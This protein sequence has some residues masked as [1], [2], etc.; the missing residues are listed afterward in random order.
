MNEIH[1]SRGVSAATP[2]D[3]VLPFEI[4]PLGVRGRLLRLGAVI[5]GIVRQHAYPDPVSA[6][7]AEGVALAAMLGHD[8][9]NSRANSSCRPPPTGRSTCWWREFATPAGLRGYARFDAEAVAAAD[10]VRPGGVR[11][12]ARQGP[13]GDDGRPG[14]QDGSLPGDRRAR[15]GRAGRGGASIFPPVGT[16]PDLAQAGGRSADGAGGAGRP[17]AGRGHPDPASAGRGRGKPAAAERGR[18]AGRA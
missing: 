6:L 13:P 5:D 15:P 3:I 10:G 9:R 17:L 12:P 16:D 4:K 14:R 7:L 1:A 11:Q 2:D 18:C 8:D